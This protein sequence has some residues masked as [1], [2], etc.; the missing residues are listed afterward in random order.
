MMLKMQSFQANWQ[1]VNSVAPGQYTWAMAPA[2][3]LHRAQPCVLPFSALLPFVPGCQLGL[4]KALCI[5]ADIAEPHLG[6]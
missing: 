2:P 1:A 4:S 6:T 5:H 3:G